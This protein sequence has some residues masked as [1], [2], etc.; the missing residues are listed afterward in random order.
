M[1]YLRIASLSR[2]ALGFIHAFFFDEPLLQGILLLTVF[3]FRSVIFTIAACH[4][5]NKM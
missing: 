1:L 3:G 4:R 5:S 2:I